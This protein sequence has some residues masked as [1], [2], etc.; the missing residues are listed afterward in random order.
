MKRDFSTRGGKGVHAGSRK[1]VQQLTQRLSLCF[2]SSTYTNK[3]VI[4]H[5]KQLSSHCVSSC[6]NL[7]PVFLK[8]WN[9]SCCQGN[10][11]SDNFFICYWFQQ[12]CGT[13]FGTRRSK[14]LVIRYLACCNFVVCNFVI[15]YLLIC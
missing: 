10:V 7:M 13:T 1:K 2:K 15:Y 6:L 5:C 14:L 9:K 3:K 11:A 12:M 8:I 4:T